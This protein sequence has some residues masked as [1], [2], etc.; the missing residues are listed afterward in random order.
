MISQ[1]CTLL[2]RCSPSA[3]SDPLVDGESH[4]LLLAQQFLSCLIGVSSTRVLPVPITLASAR[5]VAVQTQHFSIQ[6]L[7]I[8]FPEL[9][10]PRTLLLPVQALIPWLMVKVI[11]PNCTASGCIV[12]CH[13]V[14]ILQIAFLALH[15]PVH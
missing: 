8:D 6:D 7:Q 9:H 12:P 14:G 1:N 2:A 5:A 11:Q 4:A 3:G 15:P 13:C 10:S